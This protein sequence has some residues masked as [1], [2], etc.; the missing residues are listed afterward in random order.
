MAT[1]HILRERRDSAKKNYKL[2]FN[3]IFTEWGQQL[4]ARAE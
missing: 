4:N 2:E 1:C 3:E